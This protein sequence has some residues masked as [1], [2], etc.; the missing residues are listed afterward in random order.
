VPV[1]GRLIGDPADAREVSRHHRVKYG[2]YIKPSA[3]DEPLTP[4]E[5]ASFELVPA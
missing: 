5:Q 1:R 4:G 3:G 2:D